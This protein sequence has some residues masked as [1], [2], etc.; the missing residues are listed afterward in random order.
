[1]VV[2][3]YVRG[4]DRQTGNPTK[5]HI[6]TGYASRQAIALWQAGGYIVEMAERGATV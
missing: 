5:Y 2:R 4:T 1:M 3:V 6:F